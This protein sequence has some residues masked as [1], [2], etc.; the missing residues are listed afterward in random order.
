MCSLTARLLPLH[1]PERGCVV[2]DQPQH[3][4]TSRL[5][6]LVF[7]TAALRGFM[8]PT[9]VKI[10]EVFP[11]HE[12]ERGCVVLDQ[13]QHI[14]TSRLL[15]LV[16]DTAALQG[17][18]APTHVKILEVFPLHEPEKS[19]H[20]GPLPRAERGRGS[21]MAPHSSPGRFREFNARMVSGNSLLVRRAQGWGEG[22]SL[23]V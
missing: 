7:D 5:L 9:H 13:P 8:G 19:P 20:P 22:D 18:M 4:A 17:F 16:F 12:P 23:Q 1:E 2:I 14:A 6:R 15:R 21:R 3:I 11:F 10:F